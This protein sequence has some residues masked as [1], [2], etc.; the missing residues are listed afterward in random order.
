MVPS[1]SSGCTVQEILRTY[2]KKMRCR[3]TVQ[4]ILRTSSLRRLTR[5]VPVRAA[6][7]QFTLPAAAG[8]FF[9]L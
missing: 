8:E 5:L 6:V 1:T 4:E 9:S 7:V 2:E 3:C